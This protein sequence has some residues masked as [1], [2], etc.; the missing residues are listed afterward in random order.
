MMREKT[1]VL[2]PHA[3]EMMEHFVV[4]DT[5]QDKGRDKSPV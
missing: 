2:A 5:F 4:D 3:Y 1:A